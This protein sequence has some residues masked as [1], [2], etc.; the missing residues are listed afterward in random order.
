[1]VCDNVRAD[2]LA[3]AVR[4]GTVKLTKRLEKHIRTVRKVRKGIPIKNSSLVTGEI[5]EHIPAMRFLIR[6]QIGKLQ[7]ELKE[8]IW[9]VAVEHEKGK[10]DSM[11]ENFLRINGVSKFHAIRGAQIIERE[12]EMFVSYSSLFIACKA[13]CEINKGL[14]S[15]ISHE[16]LSTN[17]AENELELLFKNAIMVFETTSLIIGIIQ[18]FQLRGLSE[19]Q[20]LKTCIFKELAEAEQKS[21]QTVNKSASR[22]IPSSQREETIARHRNLMESAIQV[23]SQW[24]HFEDQIKSMQQNVSALAQRIPSLELT[25][26]NAKVQLDFL[27]LVAVTRMMDQTIRDI[28]GLGSLELDLAPL[29]QYDV[30]R[31]IGVTPFLQ[32]D[33][34]APA[35]CSVD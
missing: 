18:N 32:G 23:R 16:R 26:D 5:Q 17:A 11:R 29:T 7:V 22:G 21:Q 9:M 35:A 34:G 31:L 3:T 25:R 10:F 24:H 12:K 6:R 33:V 1:M 20:A 30:C 15:K 13:C 19:F 2:P 27:E 4:K 8:L 14:L 28:E